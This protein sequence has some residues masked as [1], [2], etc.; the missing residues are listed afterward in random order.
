[1]KVV[2]IELPEEID[3][4]HSV[5]VR[6]PW[7][8]ILQNTDVLASGPREAAAG[9]SR[10][11]ARH[12]TAAFRGGLPRS[13][14]EDHSRLKLYEPVGD[15]TVERLEDPRAALLPSL[16][17]RFK[18]ARYVKQKAERVESPGVL[19]VKAEGLGAVC[20]SACAHIAG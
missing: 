15:Q 6:E 10:A 18:H 2:H 12:W 16:R 14:V 1:V 20:E 8:H 19:G 7:E 11:V 4:R 13:G 9:S 17:E 5:R 3:H